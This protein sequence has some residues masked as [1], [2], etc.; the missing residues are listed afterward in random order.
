MQALLHSAGD[1]PGRDPRVRGWRV[2]ASPPLP[3]AL[4]RARRRCLPISLPLDHLSRSSSPFPL[5]FTPPPA[6]A[7]LPPQLDTLNQWINILQSVQLPFAVIPVRALPCPHAPAPGAA[8]AGLAVR[9]PTAGCPASLPQQHG[10]APPRPTP[11]PLHVP[12]PCLLPAAAAAADV[13]HGNHGARVCEQARHDRCITTPGQPWAASL[14]EL[15]EQGAGGQAS[16]S[17]SCA[18]ALRYEAAPAPPA[19][20]LTASPPAL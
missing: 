9:Q 13:Q 15:L 14:W 5:I 18:A 20:Q 19:S 3:A 2:Q 11:P 12:R 6:P 4:D 8:P 17:P 7:N 1:A 16:G 10:L